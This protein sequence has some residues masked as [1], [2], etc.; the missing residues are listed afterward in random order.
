MQQRV[1]P[2]LVLA[3]A[4]LAACGPRGPEAIVDT[5]GGPVHVR[6]E[7]AATEA[8]RNRGLMYRSSLADGDGMLFVFETED[9]QMFWM[10]N[11]LIPLDMVFIGG[12]GR[13][14]GVHANAKPLSTT[15]VG[16]GVPSRWVLEVPGGFAERRGLAAGQHVELRGVP[17]S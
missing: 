3:A 13:I 15:P 2:A 17:S 14:V 11:T 12:D 5:P 4:L 16:V 9:V 6:L 1:M 8:A 10:K 7:V